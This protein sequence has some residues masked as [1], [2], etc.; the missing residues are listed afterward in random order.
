[1][2]LDEQIDEILNWHVACREEIRIASQGFDDPKYAEEQYAKV[3]ASH[4]N[5]AK[6]QL[7][8]L[9]DD[10]QEKTAEL[11]EEIGYKS[12]IN[13]ITMSGEVKDE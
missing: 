3:V 2:K 13:H 10:M 8:A 9:I 4:K 1:M 7:L 11:H 6:Q 12:G 5:K